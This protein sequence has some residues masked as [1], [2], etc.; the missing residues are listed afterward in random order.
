M[1]NLWRKSLNQVTGLL[2]AILLPILSGCE[3]SRELQ[4]LSR[5]EF[6]LSGVTDVTLAG[7]D[8]QNVQAIADVSLAD[9]LVIYAAAGSENLPL[10]LK[11]LVEVRNPNPNN[12]AL[13][14]ADW[15]LL[16]DGYEIT[17]GTYEERVEIPA[18]GG[19]ATF[20]IPVH[21]NLKES[22]RG[23]SQLAMISLGLNLANIGGQASRITLRA[24]PYIMV[25][26]R[27]IAYPGYIDIQTEF[28]SGQQGSP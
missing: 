4:S 19:I 10:S 24:R 22:L 18:Y 5:C 14:K 1:T 26:R 15:I 27:L 21:A 17:S 16:I 13:N 2:L 23:E 20:S 6:R 28:T 7:V 3:S 25:G 12:A 9:A 8:V 11:A